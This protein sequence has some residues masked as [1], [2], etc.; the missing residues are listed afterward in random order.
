MPVF[1]AFEPELDEIAEKCASDDAGVRRVAMLEL[2]D[3][4]E[5]G[6]VPLL[7]KGLH[8]TDIMVREAAVKALDAHDGIEVVEA[9]IAALEDPIPGV[10]FAAAEVLAEKKVQAAAPLLI[11]RCSHADAF[12]RAASLRALRELIDPR[13][14]QAALEG[15]ADPVADVRREAIGVLGYLKAEEA[16]PA[17]VAAAK[18]ADFSVRR[19]VMSALVFSQ[20]GGHGTK[21]LLGGLTDENWQV[22]E[23]AAASI[24]KIVYAE[25]IDAL[26]AAMADETWQVRVK[27]ANALGRTHAARAIP[28]LGAALTHDISNLRKEA[29][30]ALGEIADP[31]ALPYLEAAK[32]EPDPDV[33]KLIRWAISRCQAG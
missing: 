3:I 9:L 23:A 26:I 30:A 29:A 24:G 28:A 32:D 12:V 7:L 11:A 15:L 13:A 27:A 18:D 20:A 4:V 6:A 10:K 17:L 33:R 14:L 8:D 31:Q 5:D 16:L 19:A 22:R 2:A 1:D 25:A 21:A